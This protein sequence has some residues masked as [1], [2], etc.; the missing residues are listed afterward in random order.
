MN[1]D[2]NIYCVNTGQYIPITGGESL[3]DIYNRMEPKPHPH[4]VMAR[5][6]NKSED[7]RFSVYRPKQV[8]FLGLEHA[9]A[10]RAYIRTLCMVMY[11]AVNDR[12]PGKRLRFMHN[13]SGGYYCVFKH[14]NQPITPEV[15][16]RIQSKMEEIIE[17][18]IPLV[19]HER[20]TK[21]VI[22]MFR[23][24]GLNDKVRPADNIW[25]RARAPSSTP[26]IISWAT[27]STVSTDR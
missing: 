8:E 24:Q 18:N 15:I 19:G 16:D 21:D 25:C 23:Q 4:P 17:H 1:N 9:S 2:L 11:K 6:N 14:D 12:Y 27:S 26:N 13:V 7:L 3:L 5:V 20:L 22:E 10:Q